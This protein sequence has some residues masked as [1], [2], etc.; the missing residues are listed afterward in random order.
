[1]AVAI[2][3]LKRLPDTPEN[4]KHPGGF[5]GLSPSGHGSDQ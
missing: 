4:P 2:E 5:V 1:M 3:S